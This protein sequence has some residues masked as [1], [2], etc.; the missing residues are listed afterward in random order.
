LGQLSQSI[1]ELG[2]DCVPMWL[3]NQFRNPAFKG[4]ISVELVLNEKGQVIS[5]R[6]QKPVTMNTGSNLDDVFKDGWD[7]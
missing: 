2:A 6:V 5:A 4:M 7:N 1:R 3:P